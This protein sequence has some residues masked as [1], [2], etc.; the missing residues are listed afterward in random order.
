[1]AA[2]TV[3]W[4]WQPT[5]GSSSGWTSGSPGDVRPRDPAPGVA[6]T[7]KVE[8]SPMTRGSPAAI[9]GE[10]RFHAPELVAREP[11]IDLHSAARKIVRREHRVAVVLAPGNQQRRFAGLHH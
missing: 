3:W 5:R 10:E 7:G 8:G 1:A 9:V 4:L 2:S 11:Q 6:V